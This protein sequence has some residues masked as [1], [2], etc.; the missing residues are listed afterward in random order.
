MGRGGEGRGGDLKRIFCCHNGEWS[1]NW[2]QMAHGEGKGVEIPKK[3]I[4]SPPNFYPPPSMGWEWGR[5]GSV[6]KISL[7]WGV[8]GEAGGEGF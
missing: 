1:R 5:K 3:E 2:G 6:F 7:E 4:Y 8:V